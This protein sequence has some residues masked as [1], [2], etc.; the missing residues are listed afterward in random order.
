[1]N[2][3]IERLKNIASMSTNAVGDSEKAFI[4][5]QAEKHGVTLNVKKNCKSCYIDAAIEIYKAIKD[6]ETEQTTDT[7][8]REWKLK[9][10]V[11]VVW[12]GIR[13]NAATI[14]DE[15]AVKYIKAGFPRFYFE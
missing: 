13:I 9:K 10:G 1:M 5:E 6:A 3:I 11:D 8:D 4:R 14:T 15:K 7:T 12:N 2:E